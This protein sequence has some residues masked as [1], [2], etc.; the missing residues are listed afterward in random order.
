MSAS[1]L[2]IKGFNAGYLLQ[3]HLPILAEMLRASLA[4][5]DNDFA[6][7]F[8]AG[9][10]EMQQEQRRGKSLSQLRDSA[11]SVGRADERNKDKEIDR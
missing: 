4:N 6:T 1:K 5:S 8:V 2:E 11:K 10:N 7:A 3:K 9:S